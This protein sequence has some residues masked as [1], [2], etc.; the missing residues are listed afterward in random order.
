MLKSSVMTK[1]LSQ[2]EG[3]APKFED[4]R[5]TIDLASALYQELVRHQEEQT[6]RFDTVIAKREEQRQLD[7]E[8]DRILKEAAEQAR[9]ERCRRWEEQE[10]AAA[11]R[12]GKAGRAQLVA[13][14]AEKAAA[15][16][17]AVALEKENADLAG[18]SSMSMYERAW[19]GGTLTNT[20]L[21]ASFQDLPDRPSGA[22]SRYFFEKRSR[23]CDQSVETDYLTTEGFYRLVR[24]VRHLQADLA[25]EKTVALQKVF[26]KMDIR[27]RGEISLADI[28]IQIETQEAH[29]LMPV[30]DALLK[31]SDSNSNGLLDIDEFPAFYLGWLELHRIFEVYDDCRLEEKW[32]NREHLKGQL[33]FTEI[34]LLS[35]VFQ[36][37]KAKSV[38]GRQ[39]ALFD[40]VVAS[41]GEKR[42]RPTVIT[43]TRIVMAR[44]QYNRLCAS[45][46]FLFSAL[47]SADWAEVGP[48]L[49][50]QI[51]R[52]PIRQGTKSTLLWPTSLK[53]TPSTYLNTSNCTESCGLCAQ[54][55]SMSRC[56][57]SH[58]T[59]TA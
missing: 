44:L 10:Q 46:L 47:S 59:F 36:G 33:S 56:I 27:R 25:A 45:A 40:P 37:I 3:H 9:L 6:S 42:P 7:E 35:S 2:I 31:T 57:V 51:L 55:R 41:L 11:R 21:D 28:L 24:D 50:C 5:L 14:R 49:T 17:E 58:V 18:K 13:I 19:P 30:V 16:K 20:K 43:H 48:A 29:L 52:L 53:L 26:K 34:E 8:N 1:S 22:Q 54:I 32:T 4:T 23:Y 15:A 38:H 39:V 12:G